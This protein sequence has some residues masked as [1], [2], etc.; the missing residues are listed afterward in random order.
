MSDQPARGRQLV[1]GNL[2]TPLGVFL[3]ATSF[4]TT[5]LLL[6]NWHPVPLAAT[7]MAIGGTTLMILVLV[8]GRARELQWVNWRDAFFFGGVILAVSTTLLVTAQDYADPVSIAIISSGIPVV[9]LFI[10]Y[11]M[12]SE[13]LSA[14]K[15]IAI[16]FAVAGGIT[17]AMAGITEPSEFR[18]G[19]IIILGSLVLFTVFTRNTVG[20]FHNVSDLTKGAATTGAAGLTMSVVIGGIWASGLEWQYIGRRFDGAVVLWR[21]VVERDHRRL[22]PERGALPRHAGDVF[23]GRRVPVRPA[24]RRRPGDFRGDPGAV[25]NPP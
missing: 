6:E 21:P 12:G 5:A 23:A 11:L 15:I 18:G 13:G 8:S 17:A 2:V 3:W 9:S 16:A 14:R 1:I 4:P 19:E 25:A 24:D 20:R 10:G 7:R 22:A